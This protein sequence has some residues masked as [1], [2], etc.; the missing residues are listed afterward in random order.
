MAAA[1]ASISMAISVVVIMGQIGDRYVPVT[2]VQ[3]PAPFEGKGTRT[4]WEKVRVPP[5]DLRADDKGG[6]AR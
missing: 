4:F 5:S 2:N 6:G 1:S 3:L